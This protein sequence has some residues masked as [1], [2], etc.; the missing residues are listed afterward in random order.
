MIANKGYK[1]VIVCVKGQNKQT[2]MVEG[3]EHDQKEINYF[4]PSNNLFLNK[5]FVF[6]FFLITFCIAA[7][8]S[9]QKA[10][11]NFQGTVFID[12]NGNGVQDSGERG[13][14]NATITM[15]E[16]NCTFTST[17]A[18]ASVKKCERRIDRLIPCCQTG[19]NKHIF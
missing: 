7:H 10:Y 11:A 1:I 17:T 2:L 18:R 12:S 6:I 4:I 15:Q 9:G 3:E 5:L 13:Y 14:P 8:I 19:D 16:T